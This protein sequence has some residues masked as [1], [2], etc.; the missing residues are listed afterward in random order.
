[1]ANEGE[2]PKSDGDIL[3]ASEV[4]GFQ[5]SRRVK[6]KGDF[7][8]ATTTTVFDTGSSFV[9][10][11]FSANE[12]NATDQVVVELHSNNGGDQTITLRVDVDD[13][14]T[15][16]NSS[17]ISF[18]TSQQVQHSTI[19]L[20]QKQTTT[21][22]IDTFTYSIFNAGTTTFV[23]Q[24]TSLDTN[25]VNVFTTAWTL[26]INSKNASASSGATTIF[27]TVYVDKLT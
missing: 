20:R 22:L 25:D 11:S 19:V 5:D 14:T 24:S 15:P 12:L 3:Y 2:F 13:V 18:A 10:V 21:D 4:N 16:V 26:R 1:M 9:D 17:E 23:A 7:E 27:Y 8:L 6:A